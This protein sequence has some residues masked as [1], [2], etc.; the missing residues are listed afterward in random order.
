VPSI[1]AIAAERDERYADL[2]Q[3][4]WARGD[5]FFPL[6]LRL[7]PSLQQRQLDLVGATSV[8][9]STRESFSRKSERRI[10]LEANDAYVVLTSGTTGNPK[11][12]IHTH[13]S[14]RASVEASLEAL[15]FDPSTDRWIC[16]LPP[17]HVGGLSVILRGL[18][19]G[20]GVDIFDRFDPPTIYAA[21]LRG[22]TH[23]SIVRAVLTT[24]DISR[25]KTVLYG[26][27]AP[28]RDLPANVVT[29]YGMTETGSGVVYD[30]RP[31]RG[32]ELLVQEETS[33]ILLR[34]PMLARA[35]GDSSSLT[36]RD[37]YFHTGDLGYRDQSG[38]LKVHGRIS[39]VINTGGEKIFP[40]PLEELLETLPSIREAAV[41][42]VPDPTWGEAVTAVIVVEP[43]AS[44]PVTLAQLSHLIR[45]SFE[46][47]AAPRQGFLAPA[48][49]RTSLGKLQRSV[50]PTMLR[51]FSPLS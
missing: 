34:A 32:V 2:I 33:E 38:L 47:W 14:V 19:T 26:A 21:Q 7:S 48:L 31:L 30:G 10:D 36:D 15:F 28:P 40:L 51:E 13:D 45:E 37:G 41:I 1:I 39:D 11:V 4:I 29:T 35:Y 8:M 24:L 20:T 25:F 5:V 18:L 22:A 42:G 3:T 6:D 46:P 12:V 9:T 44:E 49:P 50:L 23:I 17:A 27:Q 16:A 43:N